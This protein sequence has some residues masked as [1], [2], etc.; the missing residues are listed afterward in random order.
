MEHNFSIIK[1]DWFKFL[2]HA[3][4]INFTISCNFHQ[5]RLYHLED[6]FLRGFPL[7]SYLSQN[8]VSVKLTESIANGKKIIYL[9][10]KTRTTEKNKY[11]F[12]KV[13]SFLVTHMYQR[14]LFLIFL[15]Q[16]PFFNTLNKLDDVRR[17]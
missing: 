5:V 4:Y 10:K 17:I 6:R 15:S 8:E 16:L 14:S 2:S 3:S 7:K 13:I 12:I 11:S 1:N 9:G